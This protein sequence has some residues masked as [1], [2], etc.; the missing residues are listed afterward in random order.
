[1]LT[2]DGSF[3]EGGGQILRTSLALAI[4]TERSIVIENIR[5]NRDKPGVRRQHLT[6]VRAAA[7]ICNAKLSGDDIGSRRLHFEPGQL[8]PG[9]YQFDIGSAGSTTLVLQTV[10]PPLLQAAGRSTLVL[11]G[12]TH[13]PFAPPYDFLQRAFLPLVNRMGPKVS[14]DLRRPG[15]Y[16]AGG[17]QLHVVIE[18]ASRLIPLHLVERGAIRRRLCRATV[19]NLPDHIAQRE[20]ATV[21]AALDWPDDCLEIHRYDQRNF[22]PGNVVSIEIES[23]HLTEVFTGFGR[24]GVRA[25]TVAGEAATEAQRYLEANVPIGEHLADQLL[26]PLALAGGGS[27]VTMPPTLHTTTNIEVIAK[28]LPVPLHTDPEGGARWKVVV[29]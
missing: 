13:N 25:E 2:I 4:V 9:D 5:A 29:G 24:R 11:V 18:P 21:A 28:F 3:G 16:P 10:L 19:S 20:L 6:A 8:Q 23:E 12:G 27:Y 1:M 17:G 15:F 7:K 22:G 26:L 14:L